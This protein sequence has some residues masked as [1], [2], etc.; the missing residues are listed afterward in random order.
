MPSGLLASDL[1]RELGAVP[2]VITSGSS[3]SAAADLKASRLHHITLPSGFASND[4]SFVVSE[5]DVTYVPL[6][7]VSGEVKIPAAIVVASRT[8]LVD[9][10]SFFGFR[11]VKVRNGTELAPVNITGGD[12]TIILGTV[13]R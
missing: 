2:V 11:F 4:L 6:Y 7:N 9:F 1:T 10:P 3:L 8:I 5:D 12:K 13:P